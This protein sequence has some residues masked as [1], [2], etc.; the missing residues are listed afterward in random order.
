MTIFADSLSIPF[1]K[2]MLRKN[3]RDIRIF[4]LR[5]KGE[6]ELKEN[7]ERR[8]E[9]EFEG[10]KPGEPFPIVVKN[11]IL[12][13]GIFFLENLARYFSRGLRIGKQ[14]VYFGI[15]SGAF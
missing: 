9:Q 1:E 15:D 5:K 12:E 3:V 2:G 10:I 8:L 13:H 7:K 4:L 11:A 14:A 6:I